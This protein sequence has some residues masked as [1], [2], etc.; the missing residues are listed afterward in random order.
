[1]FNKLLVWVSNVRIS[2]FVPPFWFGVMGASCNCFFMYVES[3]ERVYKLLA[4]LPHGLFHSLVL[5]WHFRDTQKAKIRF[6]RAS[7]VW[8][9]TVATFGC[10]W[11]VS[12]LDWLSGSYCTT[13]GQPLLK[14]H[15]G[16]YHTFMQGLWDFLMIDWL[17]R[18]S[19][20]AGSRGKKHFHAWRWNL[21]HWD[22]LKTQILCWSP[23]SDKSPH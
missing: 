7:R 6:L 1:M 3:S 22:C 19:F 4:F 8:F 16:K 21:F 15:Q 20:L 18:G 12:G 14:Y 11:R 13:E 5:K 23:K 9:Y 10:T 17:E 2:R